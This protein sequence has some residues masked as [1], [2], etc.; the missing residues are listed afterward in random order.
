MQGRGLTS[1]RGTFTLRRMRTVRLLLPSLVALG[2]L[3]AAERDAH[4]GPV[5]FGIGPLGTFGGNF[6]DKPDEKN[7]PVNGQR[8]PISPSYPGFGGTTSGFG[9]AL[10]ARLF[11]VVGLEVDVIKMSNRGKADIDITAGGTKRTFELEIGHDAWHIPVL[12]KGVIPTPLVSPFAIVGAE[13]VRTSNASASIE[14]NVYPVAAR[15]DNYTFF[16]GGFGFE[17]KL[18]FPIPGLDSL[19]IPVSFRGSYYNIGNNIEDRAEYILTQPQKIT[20]DTRWKFQALG[21][22]A[23]QAYF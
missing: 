20:F 19:R 8:V 21:T 5:S 12:L 17:F 13:F 22:L 23:I 15:T 7:Y 9:L 14:N 3:V 10:D 2:C 1:H 4:A 16:T 18:P 6:L 11:G